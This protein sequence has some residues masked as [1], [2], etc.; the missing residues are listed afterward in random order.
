MKI[1]VITLISIFIIVEILVIIT[2]FAIVKNNN[3][4]LIDEYNG[5]K[6]LSKIKS[7]LYYDEYFLFKD[8]NQ[9]YV[10]FQVGVSDYASSINIT[11]FSLTDVNYDL[12]NNL[13]LKFDIQYTTE[14]YSKDIL[15]MYNPTRAYKFVTLKVDNSISGLLVNG[16]EY[17]KFQGEIFGGK[18]AEGKNEYGYID[19]NGNIIIP[20]KYYNLKY[21]TPKVYNETTDSY[22]EFDIYNNYLL[23]FDG[24]N[25]GILDKKGN[26]L[27][28]CK[29]AFI[30]NHTK[31]TFMVNY[32][33]EETKTN[34]IGKID[35]NGNLLKGFID[36]NLP[37]TEGIKNYFT[38]QHSFILNGKRGLIDQN[39]N[40]IDEPS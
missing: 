23:A 17:T 35:I 13:N 30:L 19:E 4:L 2:V 31:N 21:L 32:F 24:H 14:P 39:L 1:K 5:S 16:E 28:E 22:D 40:I 9:Y 20:P 11:S 6:D 27:V 15:C 36:G 26:I 3:V 18:T 8:K 29:Y 25:Y 33:D 7:C 34:K 37:V 38:N 10:L 12:L